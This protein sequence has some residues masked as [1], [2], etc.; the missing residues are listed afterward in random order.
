M[1]VLRLFFIY[2]TLA[3]LVAAM[4]GLFVHVG[5]L[6]YTTGDPVGFL[7]LGVIAIVVAGFISLAV[8]DA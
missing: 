1:R 6:A 8:H 2:L 7:L 5:W 4:V 3:I